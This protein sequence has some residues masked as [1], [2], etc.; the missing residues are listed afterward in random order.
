[1]QKFKMSEREIEMIR[2]AADSPYLDYYV[3]TLEP[4]DS[5][6]VPYRFD[7]EELKSFINMIPQSVYENIKPHSNLDELLY[8]AELYF[9][10][11]AE[12]EKEDELILHAETCCIK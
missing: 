8:E 4:V 6:I 9:I 1:M 5:S 2:A 11:Q 12:L 7:Q 10:N 3:K